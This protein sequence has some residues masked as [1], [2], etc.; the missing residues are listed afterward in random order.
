M[1]FPL[2]FLQNYLVFTLQDLMLCHLFQTVPSELLVYSFHW[3]V[4]FSR[5]RTREIRETLLTNASNLL[6]HTRDVTNFLVLWSVNMN[7]A[8]ICDGNIKTAVLVDIHDTF[9]RHVR[10]VI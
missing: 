2:V 6:C 1:V 8:K 4:T 3:L 10:M 7:L 5:F 9:S